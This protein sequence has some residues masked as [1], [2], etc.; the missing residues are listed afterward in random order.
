MNQT[1]FIVDK[2]KLEVTTRRTFKA[3]AE[4]LFKA[5]TDPA[6]IP[7]WWG[8]GNLTTTVDKLELRPG[9]A[10]R[11]VQREPEGQEHAFRGVFKEIDEPTKLVSTFEYEPM[12]GHVLTQT[13][14]FDEQPDGTTKLTTVAHYDNLQD[15]QGMVDMAMEDGQRESMER[16]AAMVEPG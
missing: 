15:L 9:G 6:E 7:Q 10:W 13:V 3:S 14:T 1:D 8:P 5:H 2:D 4:R 12:A 11:F 16:L